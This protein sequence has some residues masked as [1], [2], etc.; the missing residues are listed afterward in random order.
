MID[1]KQYGYTEADAPPNGLIPARVTELHRERYVVVTENG[2]AAASLKGSFVRSAQVRQ[3]LPCV[4]DFVL[5]QYNDSGVSLISG[6]LPRRSMFSRADFL[7]HKAG[8]VKTAYEQVLAA[9]FDY[10]FILTSLNSDFKVSRV[11][12]YV[13]QAWQSGGQPIVI[14]T[15]A[16]L[17]DDAG[18]RIAD[19][20]TAAPGVPVH[21]LSSHTG[22]GMDALDEYLTPGRTAVFLGMS[23]V[24]KSS[25]LNALMER[26]VMIVKAIR[27]DDSRG[28]HTTTH[29]QLFMLPRGAMVIDTPGIREIGLYG[30][31]DGIS[32][33]F[34]DVEELFPNCRFSNCRHKTE[35]GCAVKAAIA[36][37][38]L[39]PERF[40]RY[41]AQ[42]RENKFVDDRL[43]YLRDKSA[44]GKS[45]AIWS[46]KQ[47][48][49]GRIKR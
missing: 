20:I 7:G 22:Q 5:L 41:L 27:E 48:K 32:A 49:S 36:D 16:D 2:E 21:A 15:K 26:E 19:V 35:P 43:G 30:A 46:K 34:A 4:G 33:S 31:E 10:V 14:L 47:K 23:G 13:T 6:I 1:L 11:I 39:P 18:P 40:E 37:G 24:G 28:R 45:I 12:R 44:Q 25:L 8:Y 17:T 38:S 42:R 29:R 9:N 3:D